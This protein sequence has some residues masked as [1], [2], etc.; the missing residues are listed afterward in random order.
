MNYPIDRIIQTTAFGTPVMEHWLEWGK[1]QLIGLPRRFD[2]MTQVPHTSA[3]P[4][5][6]N[7]APLAYGREP[8]MR[9]RKPAATIL[10]ATLFD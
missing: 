6:L 5:G 4:T 9:G 10:W 7:P 2:P 3:L 1:A 8:Q